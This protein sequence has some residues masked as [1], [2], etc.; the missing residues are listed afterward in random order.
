M[1]VNL[2]VKD[3]AA[4][5][6]VCEDGLVTMVQVDDFQPS[7]TQGEEIRVKYALLVGATVYQ[8]SGGLPDSLRWCAPVFSGKPGYSAQRLA[9]PRMTFSRSIT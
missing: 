7:C 4:V 5:P 8:R 6:I 2:A 1:V 9:R 3:N